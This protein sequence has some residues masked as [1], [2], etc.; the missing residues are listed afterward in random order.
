M[1]T[2]KKR[3]LAAVIYNMARKAV[4]GV[5]DIP[6]AFRKRILSSSRHYILFEGR[7]LAAR[8]V[9]DE[10]FLLS[11]SDGAGKKAGKFFDAVINSCDTSGCLQPCG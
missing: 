8:I 11:E 10:Q 6:G 4:S 9:V 3:T 7:G 1:Q 5:D 2:K